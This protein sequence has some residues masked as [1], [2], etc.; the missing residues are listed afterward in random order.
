MDG[1]EMRMDVG[2]YMQERVDDQLAY[3]RDAANKAK[4]R[5]IYMQSAI[6]LL[7]LVIPVLVNAPTRWELGLD[8]AIWMRIVLT[9]LSL[10]LAGLTG[11]ANFR[12][13]GELWLSYRMTEEL[14]KHEKFLFLTSSGIYKNP[15]TAFG[16]LTQTVESIISSEHNKFRAIIKEAK[17]PTKDERGDDAAGP[18]RS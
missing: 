6:I 13:F 11:I 18:E 17:R 4:Q 14:I 3:Y 16:A 9:C 7:G 5:H 12:K 10:L 2:R 15:D 8:G 1:Q